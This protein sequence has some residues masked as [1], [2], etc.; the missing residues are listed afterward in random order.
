[1]KK[2]E[3]EKR[4]ST[5]RENPLLSSELNRRGS[6]QDV[7]KRARRAQSAGEVAV[8]FI[9]LELLPLTHA[10]A[11]IS[12]GPAQ[13]AVVAVVV[14]GEPRAVHAELSFSVNKP[15]IHVHGDN[16]C[17]EHACEPRRR[18]LTT[19]HSILT[20]L[21]E[22]RGACISDAGAA[23]R[24]VALNLSTL[25]PDLTPQNPRAHERTVDQIY[26]ELPALSD[27]AMGIPLRPD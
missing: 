26:H 5:Y 9:P 1:M 8:S 2:G 25:L 14:A 22:M 3:G 10:V 16:L 20:G 21:S 23:V 18:M 24:P 19:S 13:A 15:I 7:R 4:K 27:N 6:R 17:E 12:R 11:E